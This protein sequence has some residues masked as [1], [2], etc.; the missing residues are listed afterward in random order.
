MNLFPSIISVAIIFYGLHDQ[1]GQS[2][3]VGFFQNINQRHVPLMHS[4]IRNV[5]TTIKNGE[6]SAIDIMRN[7]L[8]RI[9]NIDRFIAGFL[10]VDGDKALQ[11]A[12]EI[13]HQDSTKTKSNNL[14]LLGVPIAVK[15][16]I[17]TKDFFT[18]SASLKLEAHIPSYDSTAVSRLQEAGAIIIGKTNMDEFGMG[19]STVNSAY[20]VQFRF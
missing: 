3:S 2:Y 4:K 9:N 16:N 19:D 11:K 6:N 8:R 18:T 7:T 12:S 13:D 20:Q 10:R 1:G 5:V 14:Q 15:D 17:C